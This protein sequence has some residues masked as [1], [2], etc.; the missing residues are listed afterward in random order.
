ML[1]LNL[2]LFAQEKTEKPTVK[3]KQDARKKGQ[4]A[5]SMEIPGALIL[6]YVFI[7]LLLFSD[8][9]AGKLFS[10]FSVG[11]TEFMLWDVTKE[12]VGVIFQQLLYEG[13]LFLLPI[14]I[15][16]VVFGIVG[17]YL[18]IG[19]LFTGHPLKPQLKKLNP[20]EGAKRI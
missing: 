14:F 18:Q 6:L 20:I 5:K 3:K 11:L 17:N 4:V 13:M 15:I 12:S 7:T 10:L 16:A 1:K 9:F 19:F 8:Y 2:Q